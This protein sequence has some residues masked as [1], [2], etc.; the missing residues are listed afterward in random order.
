MD[1]ALRRRATLIVR[2]SGTP[3]IGISGHAV[4]L[5]GKTAQVLVHAEVGPYTVVSYEGRN[6][7]VLSESLSAPAGLEESAVDP[8]QVESPMLSRRLGTGRFVLTVLGG[9]TASALLAAG[10]A[11]TLL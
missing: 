7:Y 3:M 5:L 6:G 11:L 2:E 4:A 10:A 1:A 8:K 9:M